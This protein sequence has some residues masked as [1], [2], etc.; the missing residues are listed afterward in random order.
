MYKTMGE[1]SASPDPRETVTALRRVIVSYD[2]HHRRHT[3]ASLV[4][5]YVFGHEVTARVGGRSK[6]YRY[7]GLI[8]RPG[9]ERLGQSVLLLR[10][11]DAEDF[12]GYLARLRVPYSQEVVWVRG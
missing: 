3:E 7:R 5:R 8:H 11:R 1:E 12:T 6:R 9:V 4:N 10:E 2:I